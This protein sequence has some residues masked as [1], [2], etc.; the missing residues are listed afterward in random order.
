MSESRLRIALIGSRDLEKETGNERYIKLCYNV[1]YSFARL[2]ITF[3]SG[4]EGYHEYV[5]S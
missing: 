2:G 1:A 5:Q 3:T 4:S